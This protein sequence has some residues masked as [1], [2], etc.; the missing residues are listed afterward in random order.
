MTSPIT[1]PSPSNCFITNCV[2]IRAPMSQHPCL[3][4]WA[5][6][7]FDGREFAEGCLDKLG[8]AGAAMLDIPKR[9][10]LTNESLFRFD[11]HEDQMA[12]EKLGGCWGGASPSSRQGPSLL[13][14]FFDKGSRDK[15]G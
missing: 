14:I 6:I 8:S 3:L 7:I 1:F 10:Y 15:M 13:R 9:S 11:F 12:V 4:K 5:S 2:Q